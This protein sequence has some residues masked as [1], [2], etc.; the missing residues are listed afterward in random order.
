MAI[1][2]L[3]PI[4]PVIVSTSYKQVETDIG[5]RGVLLPIAGDK[6]GLMVYRSLDALEDDYDIDTPTCNQANAYFNGASDGAIYVMNYDKNYTASAPTET[7]ATTTDKT[8]TV[9]LDST[10][11]G[12]LIHALEKYYFAG[13]EYVL[14][15]ISTADDIKLALTVSNFVEAQDSGYLVLSY[16]TDP[17]T[18]PDFSQFAQIQK[19]RSTKVFSLPSDKDVDNTFGAD[20]LGHYVELK[21]GSNAKFVGELS[22]EPQD[23]YEFTND[24]L[25]VYD[26]YQIA[27]YAY[28]KDTPMTTNGRSFSGIQMGNMITKDA[29]ARDVVNAVSPIVT[30]A[31]YLPYDQPSLKL[32]KSAVM[33]VAD[34]YK[35]AELI[36]DFS[37]NDP[38]V[39]DISE[40]E[41]ASG[42]LNKFK[43]SIS[44][45]R[46]IDQVK[47]TQTLV[48][49]QN[50]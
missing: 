22:V 31:G 11:G 34:D 44:M 28:E 23:R 6:E 41:K 38:Q 42:I 12:G 35:T 9:S 4:S 50:E 45:M 2:E 27:T 30:G 25:A 33:G 47:F 15:P 20:F 24:N 7:G 29:F 1:K 14:L 5:L 13:F 39:A 3:V 21:T 49:T 16:T 46:L 10:D 37:I 19:N 43:W 26:K 36:E 40:A 48:V 17:A 32:V 18:T 8:A